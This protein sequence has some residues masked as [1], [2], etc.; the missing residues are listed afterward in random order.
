[1]PVMGRPYHLGTPQ[2]WERGRES[3]ALS[4]GYGPTVIVRFTPPHTE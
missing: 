1:M 4:V 3:N 2:N